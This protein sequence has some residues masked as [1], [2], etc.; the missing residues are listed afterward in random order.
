MK[1]NKQL[2]H[3]ALFIYHH[4]AVVT[5]VVDFWRIHSFWY[6]YNMK[7]VLFSLIIFLCHVA[8]S[9][10]VIQM[11]RE[12]GVSVVPCKVNG[13]PLSFIFD[14]GASDVTL[15]LT[16]ATF[17]LKNGYLSKDDIIGTSNYSDANGDISEGINVLL[18]E[19]E[20]QGLKLYNVKAAIVKNRDAPLLLGQ[21]AI[22]K[23]GVV[24]LDLNSNTLT[25]VSNNSTKPSTNS[26]IQ[27]NICIDIDGNKYKTVKI[28]SQTWMAENLN[29]EHFRNGDLL[30]HAKTGKE[31]IWAVNNKK[32]AWSYYLKADSSNTNKFGKLYNWYAVIDPRI[33]APEGWH[34]PNKEE[35]LLL[36]DNLG[37]E[38]EASI[39][40]KDTLYWRKKIRNGS[41]KID[42]FGFLA[43]PTGSIEC[44]LGRDFGYIT[45]NDRGFYA[46]WWVYTED[47]LSTPISTLSEDNSG[48]YK[49]IG[50]IEHLP[51]SRNSGYSIRCMKN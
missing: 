18:R 20:I 46:W 41:I 36:Y 1:W 39:K 11:K 42:G 3:Q 38:N 34:L 45:R 21:T 7:K 14:T 33:L 25:I 49:S 13:M 6:F 16:E 9:Q 37:G 29:V 35:W 17:M 15:S 51:H 48:R 31:W 30:F 4:E 50:I 44:K 19:I 23:L 47:K 22:S 12:G 40:M 27:T 5:D 26:N 24:Q 2:P 32:P 10:T 28:G 43:I 8:F